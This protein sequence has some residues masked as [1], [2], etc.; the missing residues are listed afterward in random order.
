MS[1]LGRIG[2]GA[3]VGTLMAGDIR[4]AVLGG[5]AFAGAGGSFRGLANMG[6]KLGSRVGLA[7]LGIRGAGAGISLARRG[8]RAGARMY[9]NAMPGAGSVFR[10]SSAFGMGAARAQR[11]MQRNRI[12]V[13]RC[14]GTVLGGLGIAAAAKIGRSMLRSNENR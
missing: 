1:L 9:S 14:G 3:L 12:A 4:G 2:A 11:F 13:N 7:P 5:A 10:G 6:Q 8:A